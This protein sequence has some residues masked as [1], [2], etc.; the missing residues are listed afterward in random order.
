MP[1]CIGAVGSGLM[2][3]RLVVYI[4]YTRTFRNTASEASRLFVNITNTFA[5]ADTCTLFMYVEGVSKAFSL[6]N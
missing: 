1:A 3:V 2:H 5:T 6:L 4:Q